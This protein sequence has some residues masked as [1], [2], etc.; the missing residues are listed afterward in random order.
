MS[1]PTLV[2]VN[3]SSN[4]SALVQKVLEQ[5]VTLVAGGSYLAL[6]FVGMQDAIV[7]VDSE[8]YVVTLPYDEESF[9]FD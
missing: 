7:V 1:L 8:G 2:Y 4:P 5:E 6:G 9:S 3:I